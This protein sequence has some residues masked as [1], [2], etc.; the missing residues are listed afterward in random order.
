MIGRL[1]RAK[2]KTIQAGLFGCALISIVTTAAIIAVLVVQCLGFFR[3]VSVFAFLFGTRW[4]PMLE[5]RCFGVLPLVC[6]TFLVAGGALL[7][8]V[9][10]GLASAIFLSEYAPPWLRNMLKPTLEVLAGIPTVVYGFFALFFITP[11]VLRP[12][13]GD[14]DVFNAASAA[15]VVGVMIVPTIASLCDDAFRAVPT[16]LRQAAYALSATRF[17]VST[18]VVLPSALSGVLAAILLAFARAIGETMAVTLAAGMT[19]KLT[20]NPLHSIQTMT[21]YIVQVSL[22]DSPSGT[23]EYHTIFAVGLLL[24][25]I[26]LAINVVAQRVLDRFRETY[27]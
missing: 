23:L 19:P 21:S 1:T 2:E 16:T 7:V 3:E 27:E 17:E 24:F 20:L 13:L 12:L 18:R 11:Y 4:A 26:T 9:P 25:S 14:V 10:I 5:P 15:V 8:A 22:G 6:G